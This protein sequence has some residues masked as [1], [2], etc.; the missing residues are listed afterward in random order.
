MILKVSELKEHI[1]QPLHAAYDGR[2]LDLEFVDFH[3]LKN[4]VFSGT[5]ERIEQTLT[6]NG[7]L[8]SEMEQCCSRCLECVAT[9]IETPVDLTFA[10]DHRD[11]IDVTDD[12]HD[13]LI[14]NH[15]EQFLCSE[16]CRGFCQTCGKNLNHESCECS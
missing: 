8:S 1:S 6:I 14:L 3:Y 2:A 4:I 10:I 9:H 7:S 16:T 13:L 12:I 11:T 5:A 15:P